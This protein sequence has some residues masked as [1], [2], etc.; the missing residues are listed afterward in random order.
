MHVAT[1][2]SNMDTGHG[3]ARNGVASTRSPSSC[4]TI[5]SLLYRYS[6]HVQLSWRIRA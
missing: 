5:T 6:M 2:A 1:E 4:Q 3:S